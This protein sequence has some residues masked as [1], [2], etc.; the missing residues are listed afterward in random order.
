ME[1]VA[2]F[3]S[4]LV[5]DENEIV[6]IVFSSEHVNIFFSLNEII[7]LKA[8]PQKN[9]KVNYDAIN[10]QLLFAESAWMDK[11][12]GMRNM[13]DKSPTRGNLRLLKCASVYD[14][15]FYYNFHP[16]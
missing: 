11:N 4:S 2:N 5:K 3:L 6:K 8:K 14:I 15:F 16:S 1:K 10:S 13:K 7:Y 12:G 9:Q